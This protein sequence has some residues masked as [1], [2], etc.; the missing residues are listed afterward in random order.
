MKACIIA[1]DEYIN[2]PYVKGYEKLLRLNQIEYEFIL[3]NRSGDSI[4]TETDNPAHVFSW[5]TRKSKIS[6]LLPFFFWSIF[7]RKVLKKNEYDF[8]IICTTVPAVLLFDVLTQKYNKRFLLDIRDF[9][10]ENIGFYKMMVKKLTQASGMT[11]ISS[12]GF[13]EWLPCA[14]DVY[15]LTHNITTVGG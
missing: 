15:V 7:T 14:K 9:S 11:T 8:L 10:Y 5:R 6:K 1:Y 12:K 13:Y 3:W 4:A 2:I